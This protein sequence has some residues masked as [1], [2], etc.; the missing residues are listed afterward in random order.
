MRRKCFDNSLTSLKT[1]IEV[2]GEVMEGAKSGLWCADNRSPWTTSLGVN[3]ENLSGPCR[4][5]G[6]PIRILGNICAIASSSSSSSTA[7][8]HLLNGPVPFCLQEKKEIIRH[9]TDSARQELGLLH[10]AVHTLRRL[11][12]G[13]SVEAWWNADWPAL[14]SNKRSGFTNFS[15]DFRDSSSG[16]SRRGGGGCRSR[17][18]E[19]YIDVRAHQQWVK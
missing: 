2:D 15:L 19:E 10:F 3:R 11:R 16:S 14:P 18:K 13:S 9:T 8:D 12:A 6:S 17:A 5:C 1:L 7:Q 4:L